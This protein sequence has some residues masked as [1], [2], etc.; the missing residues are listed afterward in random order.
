MQYFR[1]GSRQ[2]IGPVCFFAMLLGLPSAQA[3]DS[4]EYVPSIGLSYQLGSHAERNALAFTL[5]W[6]ARGTVQGLAAPSTIDLVQWQYSR[7]PQWSVLGVALNAEGGQQ[8]GLS[9]EA[10]WAIGIGLAAGALYVLSDKAED[11]IDDAIEEEFEEG[12][13]NFASNDDGE[14][15]C[16]T[17]PICP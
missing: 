10:K 5:G 16:P 8:P 4:A 6:R 11:S 14:A 2:T 3:F 7:Q 9:T 17:A 1:K 13:E 12:A 15:I